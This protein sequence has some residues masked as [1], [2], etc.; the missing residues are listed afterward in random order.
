[1]LPSRRPAIHKAEVNGEITEERQKKMEQREKNKNSKRDKKLE[2]LGIDYSFSEKKQK[3]TEK[4]Q[5]TTAV[6]KTTKK[7]KGSVKK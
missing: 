1:M 4:K 7:K 5:K 3:T 2:T 6:D